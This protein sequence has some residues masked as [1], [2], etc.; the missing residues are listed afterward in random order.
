M[1]STIGACAVV[2]LFASPARAAFGDNDVGIN[3]HIPADPV[4]DLCVEAGVGWIRVDNNWLQLGDPCGAMTPFA[5]L[6]A[7]VTYAVAHGLKVYMTLAY[8]PP[9]AS[10]GDTDGT[11]NND[12][13]DSAVWEDY[14]RTTVT[15]Y[16]AMGVRTYGMW[17]EVDLDGFW[18]GTAEQYV[19]VIV[20][21]GIRAVRAV[22]SDCLVLGP[23][24][25]HV[26]DVDVWLE[27]ILRRMD[28]VGAS[29]DI[30]AHHIYNGFGGAIW[31]GDS[32]VNA[33]ERRRF[34][35][36]RRSFLE[37]LEAT[38]HAP[39]GV[40]DREVWITET[41]YR[42]EPPTDA[43]QMATQA[44][45]IM[46]VLDEQLA[47]EWYTNS[48]FYEIL[49]SEDEIDGFGITRRDGSGGFIRKP[50]FDALRDRIASEP[51][52][53]GGPTTQCSDGLDNDGDGL[54]DLADPGCADADD[55]DEY[56]D[57]PPP[58]VT[59]ALEAAEA[60]S[61]I[62][63][64][65]LGP[66]EWDGSSWVELASPDDFVSPDHGPGDAADLSARLAVRWAPDA[67]FLA[68]DVTDDAALNEATADMIW[69]QDSLQVAF[70]MADD[71][72]HGYDVDDDFELGWA[73]TDSGNLKY[74]WTA[75]ASAPPETSTVGIL[76][77]GEHTTYEIRIPA[78]DLGRGG[79]AASD[80]FGFTFLVNDDDSDDAFGRQGWVEWT[81]G[82]GSFK[83]PESF[84]TVTLATGGGADADGGG[85]AD[86][87]GGGDAD[88]DGGADS[89]AGYDADLDSPAPDGATD[90][91]LDVP[92][93]D[94][95]DGTGCSCGV[96]G[97]G[98]GW[99]WM[100]VVGVVV[101]MAVRR[102]K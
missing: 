80:T 76:R 22:C 19:D 77:A 31:D 11:S 46:N 71:G 85:D 87:D 27:D 63:D 13:P 51:A 14:V 5:P 10:T 70:D 6:D 20:V 15:H 66:A 88:A 9:C 84:G 86:A 82:I 35:F 16:R 78:G 74:R 37:T 92:G 42:C 93:V 43:G 54:A 33:L 55:D 72:G 97:G 39:G 29:F 28:V 90:A 1:K 91:R 50:A 65:L 7:S 34:A 69:S 102:R 23:E 68:M 30:Y 79:F 100:M 45:Y 44:S 67:L 18:E 57:P 96:A 32:F 94:E 75:P 36:T 48:F 52:L 64:G 60:G 83:D 41:G 56:N 73:R 47:R 49:D 99:G 38:G 3:T 53:S 8:G 95:G 40:P 25:A 61:V 59:P 21:P 26:G 2:L 17:N 98:G 89:D 58:P 12:V 101:G 4:I 24:L 81:P 62:I